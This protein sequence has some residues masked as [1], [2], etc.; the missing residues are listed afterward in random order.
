MKKQNDLKRDNFRPN[1]LFILRVSRGLELKQVARMLGVSG[2]GLVSGYEKGKT[3]RLKSFLKLM[4]IYD[5]IPK[6]MYPELIE[7][8]RREIEDT[9]RQR[10]FLFKY[11]DRIKLLKNINYCSYEDH[12]DHEMSYDDKHIVSAH[13][14][15]LANKFN[16]SG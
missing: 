12:L 16:A 15:N 6:E 2:A 9:I 5:T 4:L 10:T 8:C 13:I 7:N 14:R 3:P 1:N 11:P